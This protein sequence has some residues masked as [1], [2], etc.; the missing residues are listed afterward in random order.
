MYAYVAYDKKKK[1]VYFSRDPR[2][3]NHYTSLKILNIILSSEIRSILLFTG[4]N[5]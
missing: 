5:S 3:K 4:Q 2:E 1:D